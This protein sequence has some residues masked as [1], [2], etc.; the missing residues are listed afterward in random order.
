[1]NLI[2]LLLLGHNWIYSIRIASFSLS[3]SLCLS[4]SLF[5]ISIVYLSANVHLIMLHISALFANVLCHS[6]YFGRERASQSEQNIFSCKLWFSIRFTVTSRRTY[7]CKTNDNNH[8]PLA[9]HE[10]MV[11]YLKFQH[12]HILGNIGFCWVVSYKRKSTSKSVFSMC[13]TFFLIWN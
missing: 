5:H 9:K 11:A 8:W 2:Y 4:L 7:T 10:M 3:L 6:I 1:M 13:L 12:D